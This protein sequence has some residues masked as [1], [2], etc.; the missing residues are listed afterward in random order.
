MFEYIIEKF[1]VNSQF[2]NDFEGI[3]KYL[4]EQHIG[5]EEKNK[6]LRDIYEYNNKIYTI[7]IE[8]NKRLEKIISN[9]QSAKS[10]KNIPLYQEAKKDESKVIT[11]LQ[12]DIEFYIE[13]IRRCINLSDIEGM[14][15]DKKENDYKEKVYV[16]ILKLYEDLIDIK[17]LLHQER[18]NADEISKQYFR[19]EM[20]NIQFKID[21]IKN[22]INIK[23]KKVEVKKVM[24][25]LVFLKTNYGNVCALSDLKDIPNS[26]YSQFEELLDSICD[27][28]FKNFKTFNSNDKLKGL[29]EVRGDQVRI[30]FDRTV[31]D[32]FSDQIKKIIEAGYEPA[33]VT[34]DEKMK[35]LSMETYFDLIGRKLVVMNKDQ[36]ELAEG[37]ERRKV[38]GDVEKENMDPEVDESE[39]LDPKKEQ[40]Q[41]L[42]KENMNN[43][44]QINASKIT[45]ID[46]SD[47]AFWEN[48]PDIKS[49]NAYAVLTDKGELQ[50]VGESN[51]KFEPVDGF[52]NSSNIAGRTTI[53]KNDED[54]L[55]DNTKNTYGSLE[56]SRNPDMRYTLEYGQYG[57]I[58]LVEQVKVHSEKIEES[59]RY[60]SREVATSNT[61]FTERNLEGNENSN[62]ITVRTFRQNSTN[63]DAAY[64]GKSNGKGGVSE[65]G[66]T[67][68]KHGN[69]HDY[70]METYA[71]NNSQRVAEAERLVKNE[72]KERG[73]NLTQDEEKELNENLTK[74]IGNS[75]NIFCKEDAERFATGVQNKRENE[76]N[77]KNE[78]SDKGRS[79]LD[80]AAERR[81]NRK[82]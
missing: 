59:D 6:I 15:P 58:K 24:N 22:L 53:I 38:L 57:E 32:K 72:L 68:N 25:K 12:I 1:R 56:S 34:Y 17:K 27:G 47:G 43:D 31:E 48:N 77:R 79:R 28:T 78:D 67:M 13:K 21:Y 2:I 19:N 37:A 11:P 50:I 36:K 5:F 82:F 14:L 41:D 4:E 7:L 9:R 75:E 71:A 70:T 69:P 10:T 46:P 30:I 39:D 44:L 18:N 76:Q 81:L 63:R 16:I 23:N 51:G 55:S 33:G 26:Y 74:Y 60:V 49:R 52:K 40:D 73:I 64:Y 45:K 20:E 80:E 8:D 61:N 66:K 62:N 42:I 29:N 54:D 35:M 3:E 65:V